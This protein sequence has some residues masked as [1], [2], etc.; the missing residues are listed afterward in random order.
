MTETRKNEMEKIA[1]YIADVIVD[2]DGNRKRIT[3]EVIALCEKF[4]IYNK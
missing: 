3:E 1:G 4:P 2:F